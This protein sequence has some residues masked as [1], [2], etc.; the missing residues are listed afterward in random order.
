MPSNVMARWN[1]MLTGDS[2]RY[3]PE[4]DRWIGEDDEAVARAE[5]DDDVVLFLSK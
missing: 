5:V 1:D 2:G 3:C 4:M